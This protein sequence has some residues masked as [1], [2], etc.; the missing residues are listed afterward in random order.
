LNHGIYI[1]EGR[2]MKSKVQLKFEALKRK[3]EI[4]RKT[5]KLGVT[6]CGNAKTSWAR[7]TKEYLLN[8]GFYVKGETNRPSK[9]AWSEKK[10]DK[11][12][13]Q[14]DIRKNRG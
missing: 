4:E 8:M 10:L 5:K 3:E 12:V 14:I 7:N 13:I 1:N 9:N 11:N 6:Q 2:K